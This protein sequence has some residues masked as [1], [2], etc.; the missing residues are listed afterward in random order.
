MAT[1]YIYPTQVE[2]REIARTL[3]PRLEQNRV[4]FDAN[5]FPT[6]NVDSHLLEWEQR[7]NFTGLQ[8]ARGLNGRPNQVR[9]LGGQ[10]FQ[11]EPGIYGEYAMVDERELTTRRPWGTFAGTID[12]SDL[13][14]EKQQHLLQRRLDRIEL[15]VWTLLLTGTFSVPAPNG[16]IVH[17]DSYSPQTYTAGV[18]WGTVATATPLADFRTVQLKSRGYSVNFGSGSRMYMNRVTFNQILSN[19]NAADL[20][21]RRMGGFATIN[22]PDDVNQLLAGDDLP[23]IVIYDDG[24]LDENGVFRLFIPN[25]KAVLIGAR[26]DGE[27]VGEYRM[28]RNANN[29]GMAPGF[30]T[31]VV[32]DEDDVPR[33]VVVHDG[34]N[35]GPI[36]YY[37]SAIVVMTV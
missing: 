30:Y 8:Q 21:G 37:P 35:G 3:L 9:P 6:R 10:R 32:D 5:F 23:G 12:I 27:A 19:M 28:T 11:V 7:D 25:N 29:P 18:P 1:E 26:R 14:L 22:G 31:K 24:Y 13:V 2:L 34:H 16:S 4:V 33:S 15:I 17:V 20:Y 36:L